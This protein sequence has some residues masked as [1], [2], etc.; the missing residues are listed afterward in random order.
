MMTTRHEQRKKRKE[1][2]SGWL[3][4]T[5][6]ASMGMIIVRSVDEIGGEVETTEVFHKGRCAFNLLLFFTKWQVC[7]RSGTEDFF[8][9]LVLLFEETS[10]LCRLLE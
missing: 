4:E 9:V 6:F 5:G 10:K 8:E 3:A 2:E 7:T 1:E